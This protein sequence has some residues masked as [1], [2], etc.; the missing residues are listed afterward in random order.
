MEWKYNEG[1]EVMF[2]CT[3]SE[4]KNVGPIHSRVVRRLTSD[5]ADLEETGPMYEV[6]F[7]K[8][9]IGFDSGLF[10]SYNA[11]EDELKPIG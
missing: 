9:A 6:E 10:T 11:F 7:E 1:N 4:W 3:D 8:M 5:E 2:T